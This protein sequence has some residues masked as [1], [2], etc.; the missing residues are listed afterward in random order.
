MAKGGDH[1]PWAMGVG[2][3][4]CVSGRSTHDDGKALGFQTIAFSSDTYFLAGGG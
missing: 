1:R 4:S 2:E 3:T